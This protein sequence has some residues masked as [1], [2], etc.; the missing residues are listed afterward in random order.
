MQAIKNQ[1]V[2]DLFTSQFPGEKVEVWFRLN[3][4]IGEPIPVETEPNTNVLESMETALT[5]MQQKIPP[6]L[7]V[8]RYE[9][10]KIDT[11]ELVKD[12]LDNGHGST[13]A[14]CFVLELLQLEGGKKT[15]IFTSF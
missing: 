2:V 1:I 10:Q 6:D 15:L 3:Q 12:E 11:G 4:T 5:R 9:G 14:N 7:M 8:V 13:S